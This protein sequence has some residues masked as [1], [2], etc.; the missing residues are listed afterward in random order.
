M[1]LSKDQWLARLCAILPEAAQDIASFI[2]SLSTD[3]MGDWYYR[4]C[5]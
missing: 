1:S 2:A 4:Y 3:E 5:Y